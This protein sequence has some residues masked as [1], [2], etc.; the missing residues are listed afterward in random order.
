[1]PRRRRRGLLVGLLVAVAAVAVA[2]PAVIVLTAGSPAV[3]AA[4][5]A[6]ASPSASPGRSPGPGDPPEVALAWA[7]DRIQESLASM[8]KALPS[9]DLAGFVAPA[10]NRTVRGNLETR[11]RSLRAMRVAIFELSLDSG[12]FKGRTVGGFQ[13]WGFTVALRHCFLAVD[14]TPD[15]LLVDTTWL[16]SADGYRMTAIGTSKGG[17]TGPHPWE[18]STLTTAVGSRAVVAAPTAYAARA[19]AFLP[20]AERAAKIADKYV[21]GEKPDRYI[22]YLAGPTEWKKWFGGGQASWVVGYE[23]PSTPT[24]SDVVLKVEAIANGDAEAVLKHELGHVATLTNRDYDAFGG[25]TWWVTEGIAEYIEWD[26]RSPADYD[27]RGDVRRYLR[28][29]RFRGDPALLVPPPG[30]TDWEVSGAYGIAYYYNRC[31]AD[32]YRKDNLLPFVDNMLRGRQSAA[33]AAHNVLG[34][35]WPAVTKRCLAYTKKAVGA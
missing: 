20:A 12:P 10:A 6:S 4:A 33:E 7:R 30:A 16:D 9:G 34:Q 19:R 29:K 2:V 23:N 18:V 1:V 17:Q 8:S 27:R 15:T 11:F 22:V 24:R 26:G 21:L 13:E 14:C 35:E 3:P 25:A 31:V 32:V 28:E 5:A